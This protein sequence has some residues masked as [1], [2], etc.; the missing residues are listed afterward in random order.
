MQRK[1]DSNKDH[2]KL[3]I[4]IKKVAGLAYGEMERA[5]ARRVNSYT[6]LGRPIARRLDIGPKLE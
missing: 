6:R 2:Q 5:W 3:K 1:V 4:K